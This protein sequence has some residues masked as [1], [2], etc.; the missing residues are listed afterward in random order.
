VSVAFSLRRESTTETT[1]GDNLLSMDLPIACTLNGAELQQRRQAI[2]H[3][4]RNMQVDVTELTDGY[5]YTFRGGASSDVLMRV[6]ELVDLE[7]QCCPFLSFKILVQPA[8][9]SI[10]LEVTGPEETKKLIAE[11]FNL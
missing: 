4:F 5:C 7:R 8:G 3:M 2:V 9:T 6:A 11:Y 1:K 10:R